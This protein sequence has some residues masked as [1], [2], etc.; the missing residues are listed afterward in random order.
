MWFDEDCTIYFDGNNFI[1]KSDAPSKTKFSVGLETWLIEKVRERDPK[2]LEDKKWRY[3][4]LWHELMLQ[5]KVNLSK[6]TF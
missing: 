1:I 4:T 6:F 5:M 3:K 2:L